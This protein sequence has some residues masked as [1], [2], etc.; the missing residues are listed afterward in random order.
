VRYADGDSLRPSMIASP[1]HIRAFVYDA[2][3]N[4]TGMSEWT[5]TDSIG[6]SGFDALADSVQKTSYGFVYDS[7]N[8]LNFAQVYEDARLI[9]EWSVSL[10]ATGNLRRMNNRIAGKYY[11]VPIRDKAHRPIVIDGPGGTANTI[12]DSRGRLASFFYS[13]LAGPLNGGVNRRLK[14]SFS[15]AADGK[16]MG[17]TGTVSTNN[18]ADTPIS[19]SEIDQWIT[20]WNQGLV[21]VGTPVNLLGW[22]KADTA[23]AEAPLV[24]VV[25]PWEAMFAGAR[26]AWSIYLIT[27]E[28]PVGILVEK[29][30]PEVEAKHCAEV[31]PQLTVEEA[32]GILRAA[33]NS[34]GNTSLGT[35]TAEDAQVLGEA[36]VG[37]GA[38]ETNDGS[39]LVSADGL[40]VYRYPS[41]KPNSPYATTGIQANFESKMT[42]TGRPYSNGHLNI[43]P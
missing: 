37:P 7:D 43:A 33:A 24:P 41:P 36:W 6:E 31:P 13:E 10:D 26:Y 17:R 30:R 22:V 39:G 29:L 2:R 27:V 21:P 15:Y 42:P 3:S 38:R 16:L 25:A 8:Q 19:S 14:V 18:G 1:G 28:D 5:T 23:N 20:N 40:R 34:K 35:A 12:F 9:E 4:L 32:S 11:T